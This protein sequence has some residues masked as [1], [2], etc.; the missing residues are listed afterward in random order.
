MNGKTVRINLGLILAL[1]GLYEL[2]ARLGLIGKAHG[3]MEYLVGFALSGAMIYLGISVVLGT[4]KPLN[5]HL[6]G[7]S[8]LMCIGLLMLA[9][10]IY[11]VHTAV[12]DD[13]P[14][15]YISFALICCAAGVAASLFLLSSVHATI[16]FL[17]RSVRPKR[18]E[19]PP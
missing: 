12:G 19:D 13:R 4:L 16:S 2:T 11:A 7:Q 1:L 14:A 5:L 6:A 3:S 10:I 15:G 8:L 17:L 18:Q 9:G